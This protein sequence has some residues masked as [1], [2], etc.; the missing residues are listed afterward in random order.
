MDERVMG[1][2]IL[3]Q[4]VA[5]PDDERLTAGLQRQGLLETYASGLRSQQQ[6]GT[7]AEYYDYMKQLNPRRD[8]DLALE[9]A[10]QQ[11]KAWREVSGNS[12][13]EIVKRVSGAIKSAP[14]M[15]PN[16]VAPVVEPVPPRHA[17]HVATIS[18]AIRRA[19]KRQ[20]AASWE[21]S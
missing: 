18:R 8:P 12:W 5:L 10:R 17:E 20:T 7:L 1:R 15:H 3:P 14:E 13:G 9:H 6:G 11:V 16:D 2:G 4:Q 19:R 21:R